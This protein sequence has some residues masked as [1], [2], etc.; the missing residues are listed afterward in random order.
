VA[1]AIVFSRGCAKSQKSQAPTCADTYVDNGG[2]PLGPPGVVVDDTYVYWTLVDGY[3]SVW[4][5]PQAGGEAE[6]F[7]E[8]GGYPRAMAID[9]SALYVAGGCEG[10]VW[11]VPLGGGA[12]VSLVASDPVECVHGIAVDATRVYY[13]TDDGVW[14]V[15]LDGGDPVPL[16]N[17]T[18]CLGTLAASATDLYWTNPCSTVDSTLGAIGTVPKTGGASS[19]VDPGV[20]SGDALAIDATDVYWAADN[21]IEYRPLASGTISMIEPIP[22]TPA[23]P[24]ALA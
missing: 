5:Q 9:A 1:S 21:Y 24:F 12:P 23:A 10:H 11:R 13:T 18:G 14:S 4:R 16:A 8:V 2:A 6:L 22:A 3:G 19:I 7:A 20:A 17:P 15:S